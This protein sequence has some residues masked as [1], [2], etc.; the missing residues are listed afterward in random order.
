[1]RQ[2]WELPLARSFEA[3]APLAAGL[4]GRQLKSDW[5]FDI[6]YCYLLLPPPLVLLV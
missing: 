6:R 5:V 4:L 1:L 3:A 2:L